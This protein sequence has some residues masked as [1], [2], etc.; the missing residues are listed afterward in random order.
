MVHSKQN[1]MEYMLSV[2]RHRLGHIHVLELVRLIQTLTAAVRTAVM[3]SRTC[4]TLI[5][6]YWKY[7][8]PRKR[9]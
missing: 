9:E 2:V 7:T 5:L 3:T 4:K 8:L 6:I 1:G